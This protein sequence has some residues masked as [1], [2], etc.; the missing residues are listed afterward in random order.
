M[1][2]DS[3]EPEKYIHK[4]LSNHTRIFIFEKK[5]K[6]SFGGMPPLKVSTGLTLSIDE[7]KK[8][9]RR[10]KGERWIDIYHVLRMILPI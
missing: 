4:N 9:E 7:N 3:R 1:T 5:K 10:K 6:E 8:K 2:Y